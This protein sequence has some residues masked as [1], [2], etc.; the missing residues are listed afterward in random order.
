MMSKIMKSYPAQVIRHKI[1]L[2]CLSILGYFGDVRRGIVTQE[3]IELNDLGINYSVGSRFENIS[4]A[5]LKRSLKFAKN[6]GFDKFLDIGC[7]L[8]RPLIVAN[9]VGFID[10]YGVDI[11][12]NLIFR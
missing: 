12:D 8:G 11:S 2:P 5:H 7:G 4:Y 9:E 3:I 10:L 6:L 1:Y